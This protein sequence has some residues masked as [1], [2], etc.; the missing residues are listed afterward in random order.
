[1]IY[2]CSVLDLEQHAAMLRPER[3]ISI[4]APEEQPPTPSGLDPDAHLRIDCHDIVAPAPMEILPDR[5]HVKLLIDF[6]RQWRPPHPVLVHCQAGISR[7]TAAALIVYAS[8]FPETIDD[9][10]AHLRRTGPHVHPNTLI[11]AIGDELLGMN[12]R[13]VAA[14]E[15]MGM[16]SMYPGTGVITIPH[17]EPGRSV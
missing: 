1:V 4:I 3:V 10:A 6:A 5:R 9:A 11:T 2:V 15:A 17:P 13:L 14:V 12:G 8:H 16:P 7:S